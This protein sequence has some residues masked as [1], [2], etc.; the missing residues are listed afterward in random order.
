MNTNRLNNYIN[1]LEKGIERKVSC[2][3]KANVIQALR[4]EL[5]E[6]REKVR[7]YAQHPENRP[8]VTQRRAAQ[9]LDVHPNTIRNM[10]ERGDINKYNEDGSLKKTNHNTK[11]FFDRNEVEEA[12][13]K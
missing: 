10:Y 6:F 12:G 4:D 1:E 11:V 9:I 5:Q 7:W 8:L 3:E 2:I 13:R